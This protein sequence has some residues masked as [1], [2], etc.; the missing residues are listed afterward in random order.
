MKMGDA[1]IIR[2][3][4]DVR[5]GRV[6]WR[7]WL[8]SPPGRYVLDWQQQQFDLVLADVFGF[9]ALQ[10]GLPQLDALRDNRM[11]HRIR[12]CEPCD[13]PLQ[14][15]ASVVVGQFEELPFASQSIDLVVLP[16]VLEFACDPHQVLREVDRVLRPE[17]RV[18]A[19]DD[20]ANLAGASLQPA[21][22]ALR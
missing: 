15:G 8:G 9:H 21:G 1:A 13:L 7:E 16:H 19:N 6:A 2:S 22:S 5:A 10:C 18:M 14:G 3:T 12:A 4:E 17:G 11:P 20:P